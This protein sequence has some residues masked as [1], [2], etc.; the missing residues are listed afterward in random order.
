[1]KFAKVRKSTNKDNFSKFENN[2]ENNN[3]EKKIVKRNWK[4]ISIIIFVIVSIIVGTTLGIY[5]SVKPKPLPQPKGLIQMNN[6][7]KV[8]EKILETNPDGSFVNEYVVVYMGATD[9]PFCKYAIY[10]S[11]ED[12]DVIE[13]PYGEYVDFEPENMLVPNYGL[14]YKK[15][16]ST[17]YMFNDLFFTTSY[18]EAKAPEIALIDNSVVY[19]I[20]SASADVQ[21]KTSGG[22]AS[23]EVLKSATIDSFYDENKKEWFLE[24]NNSDGPWGTTP[25]WLFFRNGKLRFYMEGIITEDTDE[26]SPPTSDLW[27]NLE[28][29]LENDS[30][31]RP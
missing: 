31:P 17:Q 24:Q 18:K 27:D 11:T 8:R 25:T 3:G 7:S 2:S 23:A 28:L 6:G 9:C 15:V 13:G 1:M 30:Y 21:N 4:K 19:K 14:T 5:Y 12:F 29:I 22:F 26:A 20:D 10:G 16:G